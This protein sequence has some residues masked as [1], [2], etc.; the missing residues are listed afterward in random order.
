MGLRH[1]YEELKPGRSALVVAA[2][3]LVSATF[4]MLLPKPFERIVPSFLPWPRELVY[5]SGVLEIVCAGGLIARRRWAQWAS[6]ALLV[7]VFPA[8]VQMAVD[9]WNRGTFA[10]L[11]TLVRLPLQAVLIWM[12]LRRRPCAH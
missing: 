2:A 12:V 3:F 10:R 6:V 4:H 7:A 1:G 8:N 11:A 5:A 9:Y